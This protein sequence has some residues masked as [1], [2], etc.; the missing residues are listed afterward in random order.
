M[1]KNINAL[2]EKGFVEAVDF[3]S[4]EVNIKNIEKF[5]LE[6]KDVLGVPGIQNLVG[7]Y[8]IN[9]AGAQLAQLVINIDSLPEA[10]VSQLGSY[11]VGGA[12]GDVISAITVSAVSD[13][14]GSAAVG[15][16]GGTIFN[17]IGAILGVGV[18]AIAGSVIFDLLDNL[19][20]GAIT[21]FFDN[22]IDWVR[23]D[24]PQAFYA[25]QFDPAQNEFVFSYE[26]SKDSNSEMRAAV[27][28]LSDAFQSKVE[29]VI[30]FVG[31]KATF[32]PGYD[33]ITTVWGKKHFDKK[34]ASYIAGNENAKLGYSSDPT[35]VVN[36]TIGAVLRHMNFSGGNPIL[37][38]AYELWKADV[39]ARMG[40][41][42]ATFASSDALTKLQSLVGLAHFANGYRQNPETY[43]KLMASDAAIG[44]TILQ[45]YLEAQ[46]R[47]FN[48]A[49]ILRGS[50]L[51]TETIGSAAA[52]DM[53]YLDGP[54]WRAIARGGNDIIFA[55]TA[56]VQIIDGGTGVDVAV[57]Q[58]S[59]AE[60]K[61]TIAD[62]T[63]REVILTD[64]V[65][66][67]QITVTEVETFRFNPFYS[68]RA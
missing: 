59:R 45:Q 34:Y 68:A 25:A 37:S 60:Y 1:S 4:G 66:K 64:I 50:H 8:F 21:G 43:D 15:A 62:A 20:D 38:Q 5:F 54:A 22:I 3:L 23:N 26:Y 17:G 6:F 53:I 57:L 30:D 35:T 52:G 65:S 13:L 61:A 55:G 36:D 7:D 9:Y 16:I 39:A 29:S 10:L 49:T 58:R 33:N 51:R 67:A 48:D 63:S 19:F 24:S 42:N 47:G 44:V 56:A 27:K 2:V 14:F 12:I 41:S 18:G 11:I 32:D 28:A 40:G 31:Q 46:S